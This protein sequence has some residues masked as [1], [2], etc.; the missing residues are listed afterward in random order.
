M[1]RHLGLQFR[2]LWNVNFSIFDVFGY[3]IHQLCNLYFQV[4]GKNRF[5]VCD[6]LVNIL[7]S[8]DKCVERKNRE[9]ILVFHQNKYVFE[10]H[11]INFK[12]VK[13]FLIDFEILII[14]KSLNYSC[15]KHVHSSNLRSKIL[16]QIIQVDFRIPIC[17]VNSKT[18][19]ESSR[20]VKDQIVLMDDKVFEIMEFLWSLK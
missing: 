17:K 3:F 6:F 20:W 13:C 1:A 16:L 8:K 11:N 10:G 4:S 9:E 5:L 7:Q 12:T 14:V 18:P 19:C 2:F 15:Q